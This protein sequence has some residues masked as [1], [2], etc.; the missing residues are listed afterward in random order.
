MMMVAAGKMLRRLIFAGI[1]I[2]MIR[3]HGY[4]AGITE[5]VMVVRGDLCRRMLDLVDYLRGRGAGINQH[6]RHAEHDK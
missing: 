3:L 4:S 5:N 2:M 1:V 6:N